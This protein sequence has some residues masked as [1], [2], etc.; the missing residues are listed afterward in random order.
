MPRA[1]ITDDEGNKALEA[2]GTDIKYLLSRHE[3]SIENQKLFYHHGVTSLEKLSN[4]AKDRDDLVAVLKDHW[5][6]DASRTLEDRVQ[7]AAITCA[8]IN[9][10]TRSQ[11]AAEVDAEYD[12]LQW[13]RPVVAGEWAAMRSALEKRYGYLDD[14]IY[15]PKNL[16]RRSWRRLKVANTGPK[17]SQ[18]LFRKKKLSPIPWCL[19]GTPRADWPRAEDL[20]KC[21]NQRTLKNFVGA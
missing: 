12:T 2:A 17:S 10:K 3:V 11:R 21:L 9:A 18:K 19:F 13:S 1:A 4:F 14:K 20:R 15:P 6:S 16:L 8:F 7:V 5:E